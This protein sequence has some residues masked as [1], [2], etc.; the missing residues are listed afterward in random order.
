MFTF[1]GLPIIALTIIIVFILGSAAFAYYKKDQPLLSFI[2]IVGS[3]V[4]IVVTVL[5]AKG[6]FTTN[7]ESESDIDFSAD[8]PS[9]HPV[10]QVEMV[11]DVFC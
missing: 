4:A 2:S 1:Q 5:I 8:F 7:K 3:V 11:Y 6:T 10:G 9:C